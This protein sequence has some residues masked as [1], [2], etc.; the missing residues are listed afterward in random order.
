M[1]DRN[2]DI[3]SIKHAGTTLRVELPL[4]EVRTVTHEKPFALAG[5]TEPGYEEE[6]GT[7]TD[8][9]SWSLRI[10]SNSG[11]LSASR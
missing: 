10:M 1:L 6:I 8:Q 3:E 11:N 7:V 2:N 5:S 9:G 4:T